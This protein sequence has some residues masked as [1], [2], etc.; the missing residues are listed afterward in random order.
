MPWFLN[1]CLSAFIVLLPS[2]TKGNLAASEI[3]GPRAFPLRLYMSS[4]SV[5][6]F[7]FAKKLKVTVGI[8]SQQFILPKIWGISFNLFKL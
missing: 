3:L 7:G 8:T 5:L 2:H 6:M 4:Q 1:H